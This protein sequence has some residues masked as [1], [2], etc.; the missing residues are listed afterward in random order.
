V[1]SNSNLLTEKGLNEELAREKKGETEEAEKKE[2]TVYCNVHRFLAFPVVETR[3]KK[4]GNNRYLS[5][6]TGVE[7][8]VERD[9]RVKKLYLIPFAAVLFLMLLSAGEVV[10]TEPKTTVALLLGMAE[11]GIGSY[12]YKTGEKKLF[13]IP[14]SFF[15]LGFLFLAFWGGGG[16]FFN[17]LIGFS[18]ALLSFKFYEEWKKEG[19]HYR[20]TSLIVRKDGKEAREL[21]SGYYLSSRERL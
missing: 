9:D 4:L 17:L 5:L 10:I 14:F 7:F 11:G 18:F 20:I 13:L 16:S 21:L 12:L 1:I 19:Y 15:V 6:R 3:I 2:L 8:T